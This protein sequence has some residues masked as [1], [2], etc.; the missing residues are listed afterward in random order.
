MKID[1]VYSTWGVGD[2]ADGDAHV[3][4]GG[5]QDVNLDE[6]PYLA[7]YLAAGES[8]GLVRIVEATDA[9][10]AKLEGHVESQEDSE[11]AYAAAQENGSWQEAN[12]RQFTYDT[13]YRLSL[14][15]EE[16]NLT[17]EGRTW[18]TRGLADAY[19]ALG[20]AES[21]D[22]TRAKLAPAEAPQAQDGAPDAAETAPVAPA[23][24]SETG[25]EE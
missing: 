18:L 2:E 4:S 6:Q 9:E 1:V 17:G 14:S 5:E 8:A 16:A 3:F 23:A 7:K 15:D 13:E 10:R 24:T 22:K 21:A 20:D 25:K 19:D 11:A 12:L